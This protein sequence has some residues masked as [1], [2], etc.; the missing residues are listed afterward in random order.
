MRERLRLDPIVELVGRPEVFVPLVV[1]TLGTYVAQGLLSFLPTFL[2]DFR[3]YSPAAAAGV[4]SAFFLVRAGA[5]V[6]LGRLSDRVGRDASIGAAFLAGAIG[7]GGLVAPDLT[8]AA[9]P[10]AV[11]LAVA[12]A[13]AGLGSSFFSAI[14]PRF[15]DA[16]GDAERGAAFGL[17]RTVY[18]VVGSAGSAGVGL[19]A[20]LFGWGVSFAAI[21]GLSGL[22]FLVVVGNALAGHGR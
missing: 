17:I 16:L 20:D 4:F 6:G 1:A 11:A 21:A 10:P 12:V 2:V 9:V 13:L 5:Q 8:G 19:V 14:D 3:G 22:A 7:L 18:T 15:M